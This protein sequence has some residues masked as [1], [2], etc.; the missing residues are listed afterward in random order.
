MPCRP[1]YGEEW[2]LVVLHGEAAGAEEAQHA[3]DLE[4]LHCGHQDIFCINP[5]ELVP[6][7]AFPMLASEEADLEVLHGEGVGG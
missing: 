2:R 4:H 7:K 5:R 6:T 3:Q 1:R